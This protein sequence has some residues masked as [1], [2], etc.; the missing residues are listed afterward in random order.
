MYTNT[1]HSSTPDELNAQI[2]HLRE[3][4][5][6]LKTFAE[7]LDSKTQSNESNGIRRTRT[8]VASPHTSDTANQLDAQQSNPL[9]RHST[10]NVSRFSDHFDSDESESD[11]REHRTQS[12]NR[13]HAW[14]QREHYSRENYD[15]SHGHHYSSDHDEDEDQSTDPQKHGKVFHPYKR[16]PSANHLEL[17]RDDESESPPA[18]TSSAKQEPQQADGRGSTLGQASFHENRPFSPVAFEET[19]QREAQEPRSFPD[20]TQRDLQ[21]Q[22]QHLLQA[23]ADLQTKVE[24]NERSNA[25]LQKELLKERM[26][27]QSLVRILEHSI[28]KG[29]PMSPKSP[30]PLSPSRSDLPRYSTPPIDSHITSYSSEIHGTRA[31]SLP[32][33]RHPAFLMQALDL[34]P[35]PLTRVEG[36]GDSDPNFSP[37]TPPPKW[38][39]PTLDAKEVSPVNT[40]STTAQS[41]LNKKTPPPPAAKNS[42]TKTA[43][44]KKTTSNSTVPAS[45]PASNSRSLGVKTPP[46][47]KEPSGSIRSTRSLS[48]G[49]GAKHDFLEV[50]ESTNL[51]DWKEGLCFVCRRGTS[52]PTCAHHDGVFVRCS[53]HD[54]TPPGGVWTRNTGC[55]CRNMKAACSDCKSNF[56]VP[57]THPNLAAARKANYFHKIRC[58]CWCHR[59]WTCCNHTNRE[60]AGCVT[61]A[62]HQP[63]PS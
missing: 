59:F 46:E 54:K 11:G 12:A 41:A 26:L 48:V 36:T 52:N 39:N 45:K 57:K 33:E 8:F 61:M 19:P 25:E 24:A 17:E 5:A 55:P 30:Y 15:G 27:N 10:G 3:S 47:K 51:P 22:L 21:Q 9:S 42:S 60:T 37:P 38:I 56:P 49:S 62:A 20:S 63:N 14:S 28:T 29:S 7:S 6:S 43:S 32:P 2:Q 4:Y 35:T 44:A 50:D 58:D 34:S 40:K 16:F 13:K 53:C 23:M 1:T 31:L 18:W